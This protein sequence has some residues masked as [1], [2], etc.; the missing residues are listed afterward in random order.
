MVHTGLSERIVTFTSTISGDRP[1]CCNLQGMSLPALMEQGCE[2]ILLC[3]AEYQT[4]WTARF[5]QS[6]ESR[7]ATYQ[8]ET[9]QKLAVYNMQPT[10]TP[11]GQVMASLL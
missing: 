10:W 3:A 7:K 4:G 2:V 1:L 9:L 6:M 5:L 8:N 11:D